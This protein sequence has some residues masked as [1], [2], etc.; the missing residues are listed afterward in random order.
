[1]FCESSL[2]PRQA[3]HRI[4][5]LVSAIKKDLNSW[6]NI[7]V[8]GGENPS[9]SVV[10]GNK[11]RSSKSKKEVTYL[12]AKQV[13]PTEAS[14]RKKLNDLGEILRADYDSYGSIADLQPDYKQGAI[15]CEASLASLLD[16][17]TWKSLVGNSGYNQAMNATQVCYA[18]PILFLILIHC[19]NRILDI[20]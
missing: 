6:A 3:S 8:I 4:I 13:A 15:H 1:M 17:P 2:A 18:F 20:L 11:K 12:Q 16:G 19:G 14:I 5:N 10:I 9:S 7:V